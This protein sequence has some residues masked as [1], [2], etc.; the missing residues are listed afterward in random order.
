MGFWHTGY[1]E[2]HEDDFFGSGDTS[3]TTP[4]P[5]AMLPCPR[6]GEG[7]SSKAELTD[8][9]FDGH[10]TKRPLLLLRGRECG[11]SRT[12]V[13]SETTATDW[14]AIDC[15]RVRLNG[16]PV[17]PDVL[18]DHLA[19]LRHTVSVIEL[20]G[21]DHVET[22]E[23]DFSIAG[24]SDLDAVDER[25]SEL[26]GS[27][28]LSMS[29]IQAFIDTTEP[30]RTADRYR[31]GIATYLFGVL[32]RERSPESG[33]EH[34]EYR[35]RFEEAANR[36]QPFDRRVADAICG[37][38]AFHFNQFDQAAARTSCPRV[39][40]AARRYLRILSA[41]DGEASAEPQLTPLGLEFVLSDAHLEQVLTWSLTPVER[42]DLG[43]LNAMESALGTMEPYDRLKTRVL[44]VV[45]ARRL[46]LNDECV[47]HANELRHNPSTTEWARK[48]V[49]G[50]KTP[51]GLQ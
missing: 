29:S 39:A 51:E 21:V 25:L 18:G 30:Y 48:Y 45:S 41:F 22:V 40:R 23:L 6:C 43:A 46:G 16:D 8:H 9:L 32:A 42:V 15:E 33:L 3:E 31:D 7:F 24:E 34:D 49:S 13:T 12:A 19:A 37:L 4:E 36:L 35:S 11:R 20:E 50:I 17:E 26:V 14:D 44:C 10:A 28:R 38:V 47:R 5:P 27:H 1:M 2:H